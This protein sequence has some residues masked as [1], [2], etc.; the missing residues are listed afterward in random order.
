MK[1]AVLAENTACE[2]F[3]CEHGL[4][5]YVETGSRKLL[6]D[7][8]QT[9]A[10]VNHAEKLGIDLSAVDLAVLSHGHYDHSGGL[11][12]FLQI[13]ETAPVY[14][15]QY[16]FRPHFNADGK[17]IGVTP[18]LQ[19]SGRLTMTQSRLEIGEGITLLSCN[20]LQRP[21]PT[22]AYGLK[23]YDHPD[24][25]LH[26][27]YLLV[28]EKGKRV[29]LSGCSHKGILN[30]V[31]WLQ[32]DVLIGGFHFMKLDPETDRETLYN[33]AKHL[34]QTDTVYYTGHCTGEAQYNYLKTI[35]GDRLQALS[36]GMSMNI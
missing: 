18:A 22:E 5:L 17:D 26:E 27:Q 6:F 24:E 32:P 25:F 23:E 13:N 2:G 3:A 9:E 11:Q 16:A 21:Y 29:V 7:F 33:A 19:G 12:R 14:V 4:S 31:R 10:F 20:D 35:M 1:I 8:G 34:L 15:S 36:T 28:E 30:I